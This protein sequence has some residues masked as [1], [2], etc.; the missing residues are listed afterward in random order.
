MQ[1]LQNNLN[2]KLR[3]TNKNKR[4]HEIYT[5]SIQRKRIGQNKKELKLRWCP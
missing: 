5:L 1:L 4:K 2:A 3:F